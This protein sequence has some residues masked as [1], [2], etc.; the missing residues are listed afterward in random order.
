MNRPPKPL[1]ARQLDPSRRAFLRTAGYGTAAAFVASSMLSR[2]RAA[3]GSAATYLTSSDKSDDPLY[4]SATK[5]AGLIRAKKI[6]SVEAVKL[7]Y[8]RIDEVNPKINAVVAFCRERALSEAA[9][10]DA[11]LAKGKI[12]GPLHGVPMTIKDSFGTAGVVST[13]GTLGRKT[14]VPGKDA[15]VVARV[16]AA[17]AILL[18]KTI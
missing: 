3:E 15:T 6:S 8:K 17:G 7:C 16:R 4:M 10:A 14:F 1:P 5:L 12:K 13:G 2:L 9:D 11:A 18:G